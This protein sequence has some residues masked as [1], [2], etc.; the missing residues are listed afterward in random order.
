LLNNLLK[1]QWILYRPP[2]TSRGVYR[3]VNQHNTFPSRSCNR[4]SLAPPRQGTHAR[5]GSYMDTQAR[6]RKPWSAAPLVWAM[7]D[8]V[9]PSNPPPCVSHAACTTHVRATTCST[10]YLYPPVHERS[11]KKSQTRPRAR[12]LCGRRAGVHSTPPPS[13]AGRW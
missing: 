10:G 6:R 4:Q 11:T 2:T 13:T 8:R 1:M 9:I 5:T 12:N 3:V 7:G